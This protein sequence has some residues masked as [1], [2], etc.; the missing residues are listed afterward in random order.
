M[1]V[2]IKLLKLSCL[3]EFPISPTESQPRD[4]NII[5][6]RKYMSSPDLPIHLKL[7][8]LSRFWSRPIKGRLEEGFGIGNEFDFTN[9]GW[10]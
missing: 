1:M 8:I 6:L 2:L 10:D 5:S 4:S 9:L 7:A 3:R